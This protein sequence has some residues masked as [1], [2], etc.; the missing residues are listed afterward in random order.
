MTSRVDRRKAQTRGALIAAAQRFFAEQRATEVSIQEITDAADVGFGSF[1]NHFQSKAELFEAAIEATFEAHG[2]W[3][4][5]LLV[6]E[7]DPA[8][9]FAASMRLTG[10]LQKTQPQMAQVMMHSP[11]RL[12]AMEGGLTA[13]CQRDIRAASAA[14]RFAVHD[15]EVAFACAGGALVGVLH[16]L[17][18]NPRVNVEKKT[19]EM[20]RNV[21]RMF[22]MADDEAAAIVKR[23]LPK[24]RARLPLRWTD[25]H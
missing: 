14:G 22:G 6:D 13:R 7:T 20:V 3:L 19:D 1:Y 25:L 10:R 17:A 24:R 9:V 8:V 16:L 18:S 11:G 2:A 4:D 12:L 23:P 21:L 5:E 15:V